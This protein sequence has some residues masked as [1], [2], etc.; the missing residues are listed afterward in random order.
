M[1]ALHIAATGMRAQELNVEVISNNIANMRTT[2]Y[3][4]QRADFQD[5]L[6]QNLRRMGT[7]TSATGTIVPTGVQ[8]GSGVKTA[9]TARIMTQGN[10]AESGKDLDV[11]VRGEGF[12]QIQMP[13][14]TTA[15]TRDGS[16]ERDANGQLVTIDG[17]A[18]QPGIVLPQDAR[19]VTISADGQ[20]QI[21]DAGGAI[22]QLGQLQ[23]ARFINK[24]GLEAIGDNL[25]LE[26]ES[27]GAAVVGTPGE[28]GFGDLMQKHLEMA[29]VEAVSEIS[30]LI[31][32]QRAYEM[33]SRIIKAADEMSATTS[34]IR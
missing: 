15:Y 16:F 27:S 2:G 25:F 4:R 10:L 6:Y 31:A 3:K 9:S 14:G 1:K 17:Y 34:N 8:I 7:N 28:D 23:L 20:V 24:S 22:Q 11:A 18:V 21:V 33:N 12:F 13:D 26:T 32:A 29:N 19:D 5:L 30:D